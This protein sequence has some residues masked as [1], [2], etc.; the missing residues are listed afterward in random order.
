[1]IID[2]T[3]L[4]NTT[5]KGIQELIN[6][7]DCVAWLDFSDE[8][9]PCYNPYSFDTHLERELDALQLAAVKVELAKGSYQHKLLVELVSKDIGKKYVTYDWLIKAVARILCGT[10]LTELHNMLEL[11]KAVK[12]GMKT[13]GL[14][15][16][17]SV[18][19][20]LC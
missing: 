14:T 17:H 7:H 11:S 10:S 3:I 5:R 6:Y 20:A 18:E 12:A 8:G 1:M 19:E 15:E 13:K 16:I 2:F 9:N 4:C